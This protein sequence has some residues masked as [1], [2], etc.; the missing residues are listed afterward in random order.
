MEAVAPAPKEMQE[1]GVSLQEKPVVGDE[2]REKILALPPR[3]RTAQF[4]GAGKS[5]VKEKK[6]EGLFAT[7]EQDALAELAL[8]YAGG[9]LSPES[10]AALTALDETLAGIPGDEASDIRREIRSYM[11]VQV[12]EGEG[13]RVYS[14]EEWE[15][16]VAQAT[17]AERTQLE[18]QGR[19]G[20]QFN[21]PRAEEEAGRVQTPTEEQILR[22]HVG[23]LEGRIR[24]AREKGEDT[25]KEEQLLKTLRL[26]QE[27]NGDLGVLLKLKALRDLRQSGAE[28][29]GEVIAKLEAGAKAAQGEFIKFL[30]GAG[31]SASAILALQRMGVEGMIQQGVGLQVEGFAKRVFGKDIA[32]ETI[33]SLMD[34]TDLTKAQKEALIAQYG[35]QAGLAMLIFF[36]LVAMGSANAAPGMLKM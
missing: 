13:A 14:I 35:K 4:L 28:G 25:E 26:A 20:Y 11:A 34:L 24:L 9:E 31:F 33:D 12:G 5:L 36:L 30:E 1:A 27:A 8:S 15:Q 23:I 7:P 21:A 19:R 22:D 3:E 16:K 6:G 18:A 29:L 32:Q 17:D 2:E 10:S